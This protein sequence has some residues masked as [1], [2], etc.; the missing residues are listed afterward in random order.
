ML[1]SVYHLVFVMDGDPSG[2]LEGTLT[3]Y[4]NG[5]QVGQVPGVHMLYNHGDDTSFGNK[6]TNAV[7]H[8]GDSTGTGGMGFT[9]V[10]DDASFYSSALK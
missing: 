2:D 8:E 5:R 1:A 4:L 7:T 3:G 10:I 6:W 9:G